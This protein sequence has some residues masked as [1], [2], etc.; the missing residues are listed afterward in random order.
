[1]ENLKRRYEDSLE[2]EQMT[3]RELLVQHGTILKKLC[4]DITDLKK[5]NG[6]EH[7]KLFDKIDAVSEG[8]ISNRLFFWVVGFVF[9]SILALTSFVGSLNTKVTENS[10]CISNF[11]IQTHSKLK[12]YGIKP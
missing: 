9:I 4:G 12:T 1:M 10:T 5:T 7:G 2:M 6:K 3:E 11:H 8:K